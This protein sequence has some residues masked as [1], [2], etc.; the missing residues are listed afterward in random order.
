V[1]ERPGMVPEA[2]RCVHRSKA[3]GVIQGQRSNTSMLAAM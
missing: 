2:T 3:G 1:G